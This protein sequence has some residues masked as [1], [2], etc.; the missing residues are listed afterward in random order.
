[1]GDHDKY[2][3]GSCLSSNLGSAKVH[4]DW[5]VSV[6]PTRFCSSPLLP[7]FLYLGGIKSGPSR[8]LEV[9]MSHSA[10]LAWS[11][12]VISQQMTMGQN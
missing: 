7:L 12:R 10:S 1:M 2:R 5:V 6:I 4:C 9:V 8:G 3:V 11:L